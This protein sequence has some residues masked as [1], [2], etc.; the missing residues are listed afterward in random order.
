MVGFKTKSGTFYNVDTQRHLICGGKFKQPIYYI[1]AQIIV[2]MQ[3]YFW[4]PNG[5][6]IRTSPVIT[7]I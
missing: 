1:R 5:Q 4:L 7:Y 3:A 2:G 6:V